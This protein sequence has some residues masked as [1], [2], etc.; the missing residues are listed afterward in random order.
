MKSR[1]CDHVQPLLHSL[2]WSLVHSRTDYKISTLC[3]NTFTN[4][5]PIY[6]AQLLSIYTTSR[7]FRLSSDT[8]T[9]CIP[10]IKTKSFCQRAFSF[11]GP[12]QWNSLP[13]EVRHSV[14]YPAYKTA[15]QTCLLIFPVCV[16]WF[17][18]N[19]QLCT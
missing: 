13:Y 15:F 19:E 16:M 3:F 4:S 14:S 12:T 5:S 17:I 11:T 8:C 1:K 9:L 2:H 10:F 7:H 18:H 6:I